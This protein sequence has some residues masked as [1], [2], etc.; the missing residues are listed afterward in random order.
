MSPDL[1]SPLGS[2]I[3]RLLRPL[4]RIL[5]R[6]GIAF[7]S[8]M[9]YA[10]QAYV[11]VAYHE[12]R[13]EGRK[14]SASRV[15]VLTGL[16]RK[17]V[18]RLA[19]RG[20]PTPAAVDRY[21]RAAR[22]ISAWIREPDF[23]DGRGR[24]AA[25]HFDEG[26][27]TFSELVRRSSGD[28]PPR[29]VLDELLRVGAVERRRD[30]RLKLVV[31]AYVPRTGE[32]EKLGI[33]GTDVADLIA[34]IDHNLTQP[35][36]TAFYQ[37][38]VAYDNLVEEVLPELRKRSGRR[39]QSLLEA[40]DSFMSKHDRDANPDARGSGRQRAVLGIYYYEEPYGQAPSDEDD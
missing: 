23:R 34:S 20:D 31:R 13:V 37:R 36:E 27:P 3:R 33:L 26:E 4:V 9:E 21:N 40:L 15:A 35:P 32:A 10:K 19:R 18:S 25:L 39:A 5:L 29:A 11:D 22:V 30:G 7:G 24:P 2:A 1:R 14:P 16:T 6:N 8:F 12:F 28:V 17:E 38:K